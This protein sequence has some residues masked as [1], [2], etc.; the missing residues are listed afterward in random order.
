MTT[1]L[2]PNDLA[3][4]V[5]ALAEA[6]G[7]ATVRRLFPRLPVTRIDAS[8]VDTETPWRAWEHLSLYLVDGSDH[9]WRLTGD[10][11]RA[12]GIVVAET[13]RQG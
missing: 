10:P 2:D 6:D 1:P 9:C 7:V 3:T 12:T 4:I 8:D 5:A 13:R 11:T